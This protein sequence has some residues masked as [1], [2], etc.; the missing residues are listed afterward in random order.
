MTVDVRI[1]C[2]GVSSIYILYVITYLHNSGTVHWWFCI[3]N[4]LTK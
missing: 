4:F 1:A 3:F 2:H